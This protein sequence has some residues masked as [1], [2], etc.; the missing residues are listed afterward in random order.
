MPDKPLADICADLAAWDTPAL[1]NAL[2]Q[3]ALRP[4]NVGYSD[5]SVRRIVGPTMA[6]VAVTA[7]LEAREEKDNGVPVA[8]LYRAIIAA[9]GPPIVVIQDDDQPAGAGA[10]LGEV[11]GN[12][13]TALGVVGYVTNGRVR[14]VNELRELGLAVHADA[15]CVS[16][17]YVRL[18]AVG[19]PVRVGGI[20]IAPGDV[21]HGDEHGILQIPREAAPQL[22]AIAEEIRD[23]EQQTVQWA[24]SPEFTREGLLAR[25]PVKH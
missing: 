3:L 19:V 1:S 15:L 25:R 2:E 22:P 12:L 24:R 5:G 4:R 9:D 16:R 6:G 21:L 23:R 17:A 18:T 20:D 10:L 13:L 8:D 7:R 11:I 14:D